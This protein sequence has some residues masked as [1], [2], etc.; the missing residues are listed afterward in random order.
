MVHDC[1]ENE[2]FRTDL[3]ESSEQG[4]HGAEGSPD[5]DGQ[6]E[7]EK[8]TAQEVPEHETSNDSV[9]LPVTEECTVQEAHWLETSTCSDADAPLQT[10]VPTIHSVP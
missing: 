3:I 4:F 8:H 5:S 2:R 9:G 10:L 6:S 7:T 1:T